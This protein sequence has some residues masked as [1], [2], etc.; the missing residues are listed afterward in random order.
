MF[1]RLSTK[2]VHPKKQSIDEETEH[3]AEGEA[4]KVQMHRGAQIHEA[5]Y[6]MFKQIGQKHA[7][8][9]QQLKE[10]KIKEVELNA[11]KARNQNSSSYLCQ[12]FTREYNTVLSNMASEEKDWQE[13]QPI[14]YHPC[15]SIL[16]TMGFLP[17][18][19]APDS[20][21]FNKF[22]EL[23][24]LIGGE[25]TG[26]VSVENL[27]YVLLIIR[28][29]D[30]A[31]KEE[32]FPA[33]KTKD[34]ALQ[35]ITRLNADGKFEVQ[36]GATKKIFTYFKDLYVNRI[37]WEGENNRHQSRV[38]PEQDAPIKASAKTEQM[39]RKHRQKI[40]EKK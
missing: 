40:A 31:D 36:E 11:K 24:K 25:Q 18:A 4:P 17:H 23:W 9:A 5:L 32:K 7:K 30:L 21:N 28:G 6:D 38:K 3:T 15:G 39:A 33:D 20:N 8:R 10:T 2:R 34:F 1:A 12:K 27:Q 26:G 19:M 35:S 22:N 29:A 16:T 13:T 37:Q 14:Q